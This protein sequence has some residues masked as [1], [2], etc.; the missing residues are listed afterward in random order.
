MW[1]W[2]YKGPGLNYIRPEASQ[3]PDPVERTL[4]QSADK[5]AWSQGPPVLGLL[6]A[7]RRRRVDTVA[8]HGRNY[9]LLYCKHGRNHLGS[10]HFSPGIY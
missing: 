5:H 2:P 1:L 4:P 3:G 8:L 6:L 9:F 10:W 7:P